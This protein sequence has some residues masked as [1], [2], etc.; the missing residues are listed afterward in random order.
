PRHPHARRA[1]RRG[2]A[3]GSGT[4][5]AA[6]R[7]D[8]R[9][10]RRA[11]GRRCR[12]GR[13]RVPTEPA[14]HR[15]LAGRRQHRRPLAVGTPGRRMPAGQLRTARRRGR[16]DAGGGRQARRRHARR[17]GDHR[18]GTLVTVP[19]LEIH[20]GEHDL[21]RSL[22]ED[23]RTGLTASPKWLPPKWFYDAAGSALFEEIT[24][25]PEYYPT[26]AE[27]AV[28]EARAAE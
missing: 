3:V 11:H 8:T 15:R 9:R 18:L 28:L 1:H 20:L 16:L 10:R 6:G 26:R 7:R 4:R 2:P 24:R 13:T 5:P 12:Q 17:R 27:Q 14:A 19:E 22:R 23:V 25:L 21:A